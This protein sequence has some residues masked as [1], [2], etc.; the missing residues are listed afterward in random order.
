MTE[1]TFHTGVGDRLD[2][3]CRLLRKAQRGGT[4][5]AVT[6]E[7]AS[8]IELDRALWSFDPLAFVAH[9]RLTAGAVATPSQHAATPVWLVER[10]VDA[11]S[12]PVLLNLGPEVAAGFESF[13]RLIEVVGDAPDERLAARRRWKH[14]T[15]RG[16]TLVHH[17]RTRAAAS[18]EHA[19]A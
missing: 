3:T 19:G 7:P 2:Y 18:H 6:G 16:Y 15:D 8:L 5:I 14:Y 9:L 17:D 1:V 10:A 13:E 12:V 11:P 4:R